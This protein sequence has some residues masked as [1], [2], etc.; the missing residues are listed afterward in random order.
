MQRATARHYEVKST[1][2]VSIKS[3]HSELRE[4]PESGGGKAIGAREDSKQQ[5]N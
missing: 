4:T 5:E 3:F 1:L 2:E